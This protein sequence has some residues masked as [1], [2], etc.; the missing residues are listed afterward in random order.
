MTTNRHCEEPTA[1]RQS[2]SGLLRGARNDGA[3]GEA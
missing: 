3:K 2:S 1:M